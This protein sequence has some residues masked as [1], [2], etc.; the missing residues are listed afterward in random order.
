MSVDA[1]TSVA[2]PTTVTPTSPQVPSRFSS[3]SEIVVLY[4]ISIFG[5]LAIS[6]LL[7]T[8]TGGEWRS[9][10]SALLDG[11]LLAPGRWGT[12][13]GSATPLLLVALG[14]IVNAKAG[15]VNIG[16]EGQLLI[17][18]GAAAFVGV[19]L[20]GPGPI[21]FVAIVL[22][23]IV[24]G[25]LWAGI[26]AGLR[27]WRGVP[28]VLTTLLL[29]SVASQ[30][31]GLGFRSESF[32][33]APITEGSGT[34]VSQTLQMPD[35]VRIPRITIFGNEFPVSV[36]AA[37]VFAALLALVLTR[38]VVGFRLRML[39]ANARTA[40]R[41]GVDSV[42]VGS[43]A[44]L[45]SGGFAGL[46]GTVMLLGGDFGGYRFSPGF[47]IN[48]GWTGLLVALVARERA[49]AAVAVSF[50]F[51]SLMTGSGFLAATG[52]ER[53]ITDVVQAL[54]VLA[55]LIPPAVLFVRTRRRAAAARE[56][57]T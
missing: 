44:M 55:L 35:G 38:T 1:D 37:V 45:I 57:R 11:S 20:G 17:G 46:A 19:H 52:V 21:V 49:L 47:S 40:M 5:A 30:V 23:G 32:L 48:F 31:I 7:V 15:Y 42:R 27:N 18:G 13:I 53:R 50:V 56:A 8:V 36:F 33:L 54:L 26:A 39:G 51:A 34:Q 10:F 2:G 22:A 6:A 29:V 9:V 16:Q 4:A 41:S 25:A 12:T 3:W 14:T 24:G 43:A 28:E